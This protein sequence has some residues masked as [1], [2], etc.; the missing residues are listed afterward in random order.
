M[1]E[2]WL[3]AGAR[4]RVETPAIVVDLDRAEANIARMAAAMRDRGVALRPHAKTERLRHRTPWPPAPCASGDHN[5]PGRR[6]IRSNGAS[7]DQI[8]REKGRSVRRG[9]CADQ[10]GQ[11]NVADAS[12]MVTRCTTSRP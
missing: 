12:V 8:R 5:R 11:P 4:A 9:A 7:D 3:D 10:I 2:A 6:G 1:D